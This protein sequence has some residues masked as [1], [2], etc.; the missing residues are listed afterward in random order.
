MSAG[1]ILEELPALT[2]EERMEIVRRIREIDGESEDIA[3]C[4]ANAELSFQMLD[5]MEAD[6][7][8]RTSR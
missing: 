7:E 3:L 4:L 2:H 5:Q 8:E 1:Q 6:D